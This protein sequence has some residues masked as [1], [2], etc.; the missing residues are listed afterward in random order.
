MPPNILENTLFVDLGPNEWQV[1]ILHVFVQL[2]FVTL[3]FKASAH[4]FVCLNID[5]ANDNYQKDY[6]IC[7]L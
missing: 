5:S 3:Q 4:D 2:E 7:E 1:C 6:L